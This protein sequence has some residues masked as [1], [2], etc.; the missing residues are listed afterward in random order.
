MKAPKYELNA[1]TG[2][3]RVVFP[4]DEGPQYVIRSVAFEGNAVVND[5]RL[6]EAAPVP[7]GE[8]YKPVLEEHAIQ[9]VRQVYWDQG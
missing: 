4:V 3:G 5:A 2:T 6:A 1:Q 9:R 7:V 8:A